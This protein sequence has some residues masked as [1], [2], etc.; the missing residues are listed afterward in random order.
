[1]HP[2]LGLQLSIQRILEYYRIP[3][4][5]YD[6]GSYNFLNKVA[7]IFKQVEIFQITNL[8]SLNTSAP[9]LNRSWL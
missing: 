9:S 7:E 3:H 5:V 2:N 8:V 1:M 6:Y 4:R